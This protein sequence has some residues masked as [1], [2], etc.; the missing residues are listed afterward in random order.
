MMR[1]LEQRPQ[2]VFGLG[3][4]IV[5]MCCYRQYSAMIDTPANMA[6]FLLENGELTDLNDTCRL[7][8]RKPRFR[9][10]HSGAISCRYVYLCKEE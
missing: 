7:K 2:V 6:S 9:G 4:E 5:S 1:K 10:C 3:W 8:D